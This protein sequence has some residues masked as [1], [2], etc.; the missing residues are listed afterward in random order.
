MLR[1]GI[2]RRFKRGVMRPLREIALVVFAPLA[3]VACA[4]PGSGDATSAPSSFGPS[5]QPAGPVA[6]H[7]NGGIVVYPPLG[8]PSNDEID[9]LGPGLVLMGGAKP[10]VS[11]FAWAENTIGAGR[12]SAGDVVILRST[13]DDSLTS[14]A[15]AAGAFNSVRTVVVPADASPEDLVDAAVYLAEVEAVVF[16]DDDAV[17]LTKWSGSPLLAAVANMFERGG[18]VLGLG[19]SVTAFGQFAFDPLASGASAVES[20]AAVANPFDPAITFTQVFEFPQLGNLIVDAHFTSLDRLGRLA[21]FM[22][23]QVADGTLTTHPPRV[24]G[25]GVDEENAVAIDRFGHTTLLQD[26]NTTGGGF[27]LAAGVPSQVVAGAPLIYDGIEVT[28]LDTVGETYELTRGCGTAF[29]YTVSVDGAD[30]VYYSPAN[31]YTAAG[32][33]SPCTD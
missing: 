18:I 15:F 20:S 7:V 31:P 25:V 11:S 2:D 12:A 16:A 22:A 26:G 4:S 5:S 24:F 27:V 3:L 10:V 30:A 13:D 21:A 29:T 32:V 1:S 19:D 23:R 6:P 8:N 14:I 17:P 33:S 28:R 9:P